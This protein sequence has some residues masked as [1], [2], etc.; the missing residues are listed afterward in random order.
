MKLFRGR[1][2]GVKVALLGLVGASVLGY[3]GYKIFFNR[4]GEAAVAMIPAD[5]TCVLT[6][7]TH[8]SESQVVA[9]KKL[10]DAL[11]REGLDSEIEDGVSD[12]VGKAG[13]AKEVRQYLTHDLASAWWVGD[14]GASTTG[15]GLLSIN[16]PGAVSTILAKGNP[17]QG[18]GVPAYS[19]GHNM[20]VAVVGDYLAISDKPETIARIVQTRQGAPS[21]ANLPEYRSARNVLPPDA[22]FMFFASPSALHQ[23]MADKGTSTTM[24]LSFGASLRDGGLQFDYRGPVDVKTFPAMG[25]LSN[26]RP[27]SADLLKKLPP[28]AYGLIAYSSVDKYLDAVRDSVSKLADEA[29]VRKQQED[30][31]KETGLSIDQDILPAFKGDVV[32]A[33]YP[34][35]AMPSKSADGLLMV[36]DANGGTPANLADKVRALLERKTAE[37][38]AKHNGTAL[39]F[40]E[41]H[42]GQVT[43]W[44]LDPA[45]AQAM[46]KQLGEKPSHSG[47][48][49]PFSDKTLSYAV[50]N[51]TVVVA[52]SSAM[53]TKA[54]LTL[55]GAKSLA[56]DPAFMEMSSRTTEKDQ[57]MLMCSLSRV[58]QAFGENL[59]ENI[60]KGHDFTADDVINLF[61]GPNTGLVGSGY[62][63]N[64]AARGTLFLPLDFDRMAKLIRITSHPKTTDTPALEAR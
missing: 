64:N 55:N 17:V 30:F 51:G 25:Q 9:F 20:V 18:A 45:S 60:G 40:V 53:M 6:L 59:G 12:L 10:S 1:F 8:P 13:I 26:M 32:F 15:I 4:A 3:A 34:D 23:M 47:D 16:D 31:E 29:T 35:V 33:V 43:V 22:N 14:K 7:D 58:F 50:A 56:E 44:S 52:S 61:G 19:F 38:A 39:H 63:E 21:M 37:E 27:L 5:A 57:F 62:V 11:K 36:D 46:Q 24:W 41:S 28:D 42:V 54:I 49:S 48:V 2:G